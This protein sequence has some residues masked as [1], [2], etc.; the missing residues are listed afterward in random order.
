MFQGSKRIKWIVIYLTEMAGIV[1]T[2]LTETGTTEI[3]D[4]T[5]EAELGEIKIWILNKKKFLKFRRLLF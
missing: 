4:I 2:I 1:D 3:A 5:E